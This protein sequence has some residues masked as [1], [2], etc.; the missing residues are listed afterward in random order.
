MIQSMLKNDIE[1]YISVA[2]SKWAN[3][4][5]RILIKKPKT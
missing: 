4:N 3:G 2:S 1:Y 5:R